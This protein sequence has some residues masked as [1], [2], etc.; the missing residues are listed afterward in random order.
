[1]D[2]FEPIPPWACGYAYAYTDVGAQ[3]CTRDGRRVGNA[4]VLSVTNDVAVVITDAGNKFSLKLT[5]LEELF[6]K[7]RYVMK[8]TPP[9]R[10]HIPINTL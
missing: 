8:Q 10:G 3:L 5:E 1:M 4:V 9:R 6:H 2:I 7:P